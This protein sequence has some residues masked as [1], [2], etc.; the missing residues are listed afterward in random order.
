MRRLTAHPSQELHGAWSPDARSIAFAS[1]RSGNLDIWTMPAEGGPAERL[2]SHPATDGFP[3]WSPSGS[4]IAIYS[5]RGDGTDVWVLDVDGGQPRRL[6]SHPAIDNV[7]SW[8][9]DGTWIAYMSFRSGKEGE[10]SSLWRHPAAGGEPEYLTGSN[11][12]LI[13]RPRW[14]PDA[15]RLFFQCTAQTLCELSLESGTERIVASLSGRPGRIH[16]NS[17]DA[18]GRFLYFSWSEEEGDIWVMDV[19]TDE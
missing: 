16:L 3:S 10:L 12:D 6:T 18:D 2:S 19:V 17:F 7:P 4:E 13:Q 9:P 1:D 8:S 15:S 11:R 5:R 14:S